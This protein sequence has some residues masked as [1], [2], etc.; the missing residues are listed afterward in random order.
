M[1]F[2]QSLN[3]Q[4]AHWA[5]PED[6]PAEVTTLLQWVSGKETV[7]EIGCHTGDVSRWLRHY[8]HQVTGIELNAAALE[9]ARPFLQEAIA[10]D[11][12]QPQV[13]DQLSSKRF[14]AVLLQHVLEHLA[15]PWTT[16]QRCASVLSPDG[17]VVIVMPNICNADTRFRMLFGEFHYTD[18]GVM[19]RT[20][21]RFF[22]RHS[23]E[24]LIRSAGLRTETYFSP[25]QVNPIREFIDHLPLLTHLRHL[26][27]NR[28]LAFPRFSANLTDVVMMFKCRSCG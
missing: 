7:L 11:V 15:D 6:L 3:Y 19:D 28:P 8:G 24:T 18:T 22:N 25:W 1:I 9:R 26:F 16:L 2:D 13:W 21:L 20:H 5:R 4:H 23:A 10:A 27:P 12:E 17:V 14:D